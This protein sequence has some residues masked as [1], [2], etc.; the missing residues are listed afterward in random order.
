M[1]STYD[2]SQMLLLDPKPAVEAFRALPLEGMDKMG[3]ELYVAR[4]LHLHGARIAGGNDDVRLTHFQYVSGI[5]HVYDSV[6]IPGVNSA[7]LVPM[8]L[9]EEY[10]GLLNIGHH[11]NLLR[12]GDADL[13][14]RIAEGLTVHSRE[15][16]PS[17]RD[18]LM[19]IY[20]LNM[21]FAFEAHP[22][23]RFVALIDPKYEMR[24][25]A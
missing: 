19:R 17:L 4:K 15:L 22:L 20:G 12:R 16:D 9:E 11:S 14:D 7:K 5:E 18:D 3:A 2:L 8:T 10:R 13:I 21:P 23:E 1:D 24:R 6:I 25:S